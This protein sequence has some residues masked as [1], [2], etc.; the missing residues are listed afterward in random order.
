MH[1]TQQQQLCVNCGTPIH[2]SLDSRRWVHDQPKVRYCIAN[3]SA[4]N[5]PTTEAAPA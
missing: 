5:N 1:G 2:W 4:E 3:F